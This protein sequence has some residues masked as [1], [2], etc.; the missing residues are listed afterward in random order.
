MTHPEHVGFGCLVAALLSYEGDGVVERVLEHARPE[1]RA[2]GDAARHNHAR[3]E[4]CWMLE[5][6]PV[7]RPHGPRQE[8]VVH[9]EAGRDQWF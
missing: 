6:F 9:R 7:L 5:E 8:A 2:C 1:A 3:V 4:V